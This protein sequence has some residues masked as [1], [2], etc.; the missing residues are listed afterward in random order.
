MGGENGERELSRIQR[1]NI[2]S[3]RQHEIKRRKGEGRAR[4]CVF[5]Q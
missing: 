5:T 4:K 1:Q 2:L 3:E